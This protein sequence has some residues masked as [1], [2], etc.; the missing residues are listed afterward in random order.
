MPDLILKCSG[1]SAFVAIDDV[2][3]G[4]TVACTQCGGALA[5]PAPGLGFRCPSCNWD[6]A[7]P[8]DLAGERFC[9][10][11]CEQDVLIPRTTR[12]RVGDAPVERPRLRLARRDQ[13]PARQPSLAQAQTLF[14]NLRR[15]PSCSEAIRTD[16]IECVYCG[17]RPAGA[18]TRREERSHASAVGRPKTVV[19]A[20][21]LGGALIVWTAQNFLAESHPAPPEVPLP[22]WALAIPTIGIFVILLAKIIEGRSWARAA[23]LVMVLLSMLF[24]SVGTPTDAPEFLVGPDALHL[25][26]EIA[27]V[28]LLFTPS[29][30]AWFRARGEQLEGR[31]CAMPLFVTVGLMLVTLA[32]T[33]LAA[34]SR[35]SG[36]PSQ[37]GF[38]R[39]YAWNG[40]LPADMP[41]A[42]LAG[43]S[44]AMSLRFHADGTFV[45]TDVV[46]GRSPGRYSI[47]GNSVDLTF[48]DPDGGPGGRRTR[49]LV[50]SGSELVDQDGKR[51][52]R[53]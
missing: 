38:D 6:M 4:A 14:A 28:I 20:I 43:Q 18:G 17:E 10:P 19:A 22:T 21:W 2:A 50:Q 13:A 31:G 26:L 3:T 44:V 46:G 32:A 42:S 33:L 1:C 40:A 25:G 7:A 41:I 5:V 34:S 11:N 8:P 39:E 35:P 45:Q 49:R 23:E 37:G 52:E 15:C 51:W 36:A 12:Q 30:S 9:C 27:Y 48:D 16:A 47:D 53:N 24:L 29:A